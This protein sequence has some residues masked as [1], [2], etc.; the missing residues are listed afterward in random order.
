MVEIRA[1][2]HPQRGRPVYTPEAVRPSLQRATEVI[3][4]ART[5]F[6][7]IATSA[8]LDDGPG[9]AANYLS[10]T[11]YERTSEPIKALKLH[12]RA[13]EMELLEFTAVLDG[14]TR[15][16]Y[17]LIIVYDRTI[18]AV[19]FA[20][21]PCDYGGRRVFAETAG[22]MINIRLTWPKSNGRTCIDHAP[23]LCSSF[24]LVSPFY[25]SIP[26][27]DLLAFLDYCIL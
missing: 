19:C 23:R 3:L 12:S 11:R 16:T 14:M 6:L 9:E 4:F 18:G 8:P 5:T 25:L 7:V 13:L 22:L 21:A 27:C 26:F 2:H 10:S 17:I 1:H 24:S 15:N 20:N